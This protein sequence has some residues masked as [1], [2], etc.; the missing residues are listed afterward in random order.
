VTAASD[1]KQKLFLTS[2]LDRRNYIG[3]VDAA[4]DQA[5]PAVDHAIV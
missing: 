2:E 1:G 5:R 3:N 4:R